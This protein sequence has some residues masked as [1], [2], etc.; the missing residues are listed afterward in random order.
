WAFLV[1]AGLWVDPLRSDLEAFINKTQ[2]RVCGRVKLKLYK[3]NLRVVG[4][5]SK[6]SLYDLKLATY[7]VGTTF[8][9]SLARGFIELWGLQSKTFHILKGVLEATEG[10]HCELVV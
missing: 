6:Y 10:K 8:D 1:Y 4:R 3:G 7:D 2:E 5:S 9:Q